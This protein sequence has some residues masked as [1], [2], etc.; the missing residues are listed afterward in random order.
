MR[1]KKIGSSVAYKITGAFP[2]F[3]ARVTRT[4]LSAHR[5]PRC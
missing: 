3:I 2:R 1:R 4:M 5:D